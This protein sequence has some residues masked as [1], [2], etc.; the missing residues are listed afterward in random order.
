[1]MK[2]SKEQINHAMSS[3][4]DAGFINYFGMQRFGNSLIAT[5]HVGRALLL[6]QWQT[7]VD[8][9]LKPREGAQDDNKWR[10]HWM[11]KRDAK[12]TL[13]M[14]PYHKKSSVEQQLLRG[15]LKTRNDY[16]ASFSSIPRNTRLIY[17]H[18]YQSYIW[19][20]ITTQRLQR[21]GFTPVVGDLVSAKNIQDDEDLVLPRVEYVTEVNQNE[22]SIYDVVLPL[23]GHGVKYPTH[24]A[25]EW[26]TE[27]LA[28]DDLTVE[29]LKNTNRDLSLSGAY[30]KC[31]VKPTDVSW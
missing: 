1:M 14:L 5:Y 21:D 7:A 8:L 24:K 27:E 19:N 11:K 29:M 9:I 15:L 3:L 10:E 23:P 6:N 2:G 25:G 28:K 12:S 31:V 30:R 20:V 17:L 16:Q 22:F 13:E 4:R 26:Y 18:S